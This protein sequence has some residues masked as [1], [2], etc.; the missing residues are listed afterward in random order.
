MSP[1]PR[2]VRRSDLKIN[3]EIL[4][5]I[6]H[7]LAVMT[8]RMEDVRKVVSHPRCSQCRQWLEENLPDTAL[9]D[10]A[11]TALAAQMAAEDESVAAIAERW[12]PACTA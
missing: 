4:L 3:A 6:E 9:V 10:V 5:E 2:Y 12:P 7:N 1:H 8:G 11:S